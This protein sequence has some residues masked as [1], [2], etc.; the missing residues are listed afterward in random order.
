MMVQ[1]INQMGIAD[2]VAAI[3]IKINNLNS[4]DQ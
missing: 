3:Y 1:I 4:I 2:K